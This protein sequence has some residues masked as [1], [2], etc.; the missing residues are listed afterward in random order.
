MIS[1]TSPT[2][3]VATRSRRALC[4]S[5]ADRAVRTCGS[6]RFCSCPT[7]ISPKLIAVGEIGDRVHLLGGGVAGRRAFG[8]SDSVTIA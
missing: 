2:F 4:Q 7:R 6:T 8:L 1:E 5:A 3:G